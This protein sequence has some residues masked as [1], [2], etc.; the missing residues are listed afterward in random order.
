[1]NDDTGGK[2]T[3]LNAL[4]FKQLADILGFY[5]N[6][7]DYDESGE[8]IAREILSG[9][10]KLTEN[11]LKNIAEFLTPTVNEPT[12]SNTRFNDWEEPL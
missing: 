8:Y 7:D 11:E 5:D 12:P 9:K 10:L 3:A 1:V 4:D 6:N 2:P